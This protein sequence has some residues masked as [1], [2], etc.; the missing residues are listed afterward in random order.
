MSL[1][2]IVKDRIAQGEKAPK[3]TY[4][5]LV[6]KKD[7]VR[8]LWEAYLSIQDE[9]YTPEED[10][11]EITEEQYAHYVRLVHD[12]I[13]STDKADDAFQKD[14]NG[15]VLKKQTA[16]MDFIDSVGMLEIQLIAGKLVTAVHNVQSGKMSVPG[17]PMLAGLR[18]HMFKT[19]RERMEKVIEV[20]TLW[21]AMCKDLFYTEMTWEKR[22]AMQPQEEADKK[23]TN[24][25][26]NLQR[27]HQ[28]E[29]AKKIIEENK[30]REAAELE[31]DSGDNDNADN[32]NQRDASNEAT[33]V[34]PMPGNKRAKRI[35]PDQF[36]N[37]TTRA[38]R[39]K[40]SKAAGSAE[41]ATDTD[42]ASQ[43]ADPAAQASTNTDGSPQ[44]ASPT[45]SEPAN[46]D[47]SSQIAVS[48]APASNN[49]GG[50]T[51][52]SS[53]TAFVPINAGRSSQRSLSS[54]PAPKKTGGSNET[55]N[56]FAGPA[57]VDHGP[58]L[59]A[60]LTAAPKGQG[61]LYDTSKFPGPLGKPMA[62][63]GNERPPAYSPGQYSLPQQPQKARLSGHYFPQQPQPPG[64]YVNNQQAS[65]GF[66]QSTP[67]SYGLHQP[68]QQFQ[69]QGPQRSVAQVPSHSRISQHDQMPGIQLNGQEPRLQH[70][71]QAVGFQ[72]S[73]H[74]ASF[75]PNGRVAN[76]QQ[77][78]RV[79]S[80]Q[81]HGRMASIQRN[82]RMARIRLNGSHSYI[83]NNYFQHPVPGSSVS[84]ALPITQ[85]ADNEYTGYEQA[86]DYDQT[87]GNS[88]DQNN[89]EATGY[90]KV[91]GDDQS[92]DKCQDSKPAVPTTPTPPQSHWSAAP[93]E[94]GNDDTP[95]VTTTVT[96]FVESPP[97][98]EDD[99]A[100]EET[101][102]TYVLSGIVP[103]KGGDVYTGE[104]PSM[105]PTV[106]DDHNA[107]QDQMMGYSD[108]AKKE[109]E[110]D[111]D[112]DEYEDC[113]DF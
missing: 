10:Q 41:Q 35:K 22:I 45:A 82:G 18:L 12:A 42:P 3:G 89:D 70:N 77:N 16:M 44:P 2:T 98:L 62:Q 53:G 113:M 65:Y 37:I 21:K 11:G 39:G 69:I 86:I 59:Q 85:G 61:E 56:I 40:K 97:Y 96:P 72:H 24:A 23:A 1:T 20:L 75:Q 47:D 90:A 15:K 95:A 55:N 60:A 29:K 4:I 8:E 9:M 92:E 108:N 63:H 27:K 49:T 104:I 112:E 54:T 52:P 74:A 110:D 83:V 6:G 57:L 31:S 87:M 105:F 88:Q 103:P 14:I 30:K 106:D 36:I 25:R 48:P 102:R 93:T 64:E 84:Q 38:R 109:E 99:T 76:F 7:D 91:L 19:F 73:D 34:L 94:V 51:Q 78:G 68:S 32:D 81:Q 33:P 66:Q 58:A 28:K 71:G 101:H 43:P 46:G 107:I 100:V 80:I 17:W 79:A 111:D 5:H 50:S 13:R 67:Q 26:L